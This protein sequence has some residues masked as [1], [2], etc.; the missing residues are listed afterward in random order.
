MYIFFCFS[1][2]NDKYMSD[3]WNEPKKKKTEK[4]PFMMIYG[5]FI[6]IRPLST[7]TLMQ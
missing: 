1:G 2:I 3:R 7:L 4:I 6:S 5:D